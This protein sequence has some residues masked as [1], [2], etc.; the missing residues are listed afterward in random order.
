MAVIG[1]LICSPLIVI[2]ACRIGKPT[3]KWAR[4]KYQ[5]DPMKL[6]VSKMRF[7]K[8]AY[9]MKQLATTD[10]TAQVA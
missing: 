3:S 9:L 6:E 8:E 7:P 4:E 10:Q 2:A 5:Y 1:W